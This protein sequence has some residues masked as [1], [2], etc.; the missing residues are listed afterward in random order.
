MNKNSTDP[1]LH[2]AGYLILERPDAT[3]VSNECGRGCGRYLGVDRLPG[4]VAPEPAIRAA[5]GAPPVRDAAMRALIEEW[6]DARFGDTAFIESQLQAQRLLKGFRSHGLDF[7]LVYCEVAWVRGEENR[8][9]AYPATADAGPDILLTY[10][11]DVS[12]PTC[13]HSAIRQPGVVPSN[14][15]WRSRLNEHGLLDE[16]ADATRLRAEYLK[17]YP[18]PPFDTYAVHK[19]PQA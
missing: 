13:K 2:G 1:R 9:A 16:Y 18:Y 19:I 17:T 10:G 7:E 3:S 4:I 14:P 15:S 12:W 8:L 5:I 11:F 6:F